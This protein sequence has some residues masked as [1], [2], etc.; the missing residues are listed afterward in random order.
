MVR[1]LGRPSDNLVALPVVTPMFVPVPSL[2]F[3][4]RFLQPRQRQ[5]SRLC[6]G[7]LRSVR[8]DVEV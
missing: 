3:P 4:T 5:K 6:A 8:I 2:A 7:I 1:L